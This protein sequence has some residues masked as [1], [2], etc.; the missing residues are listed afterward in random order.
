MIEINSKHIHIKGHVGTWYAVSERATEQHGK[1]YLL[2][3]ESYGDDAACLIV[4]EA[5]DVIVDNVH[6]GFLDYDEWLA[7]QTTTE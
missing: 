2:E 1:L 6:N 4:D 3:H 7:A 5:G